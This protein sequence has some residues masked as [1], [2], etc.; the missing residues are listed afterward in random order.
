MA[1][2]AEARL[3]ALK[4]SMKEALGKLTGSDELAAEGAK[5][6]SGTAVGEGE[7]EA[8]AAQPARKNAAPRAS[9]GSASRRSS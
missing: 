5:E 2:Q 3:R 4:A 6:R 7:A 9:K 1:D 8:R